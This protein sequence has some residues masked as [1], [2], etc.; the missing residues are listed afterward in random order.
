MRDKLLRFPFTCAAVCFAVVVVV[1][2][3]IGDVNL[4]E[5]PSAVMNRIEQHEVDDIFTV[6]ALVIVAQVADN[7]RAARRQKTEAKRQRGQL[8]VVHVTMRTVQDIVNNGLNQLQLL[9]VD[10]EGLVPEESL[11]LFDKT[12]QETSAKLKALGN[13]EVFVEKQMAAGSGLNV[14]GQE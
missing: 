4:I 7:F 3:L 6:L 1:A 11:V 5:V 10:A 8:R 12:I 2:A 14:P 13:L 9:R